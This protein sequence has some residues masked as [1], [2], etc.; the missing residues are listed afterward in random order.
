M[1]MP[2]VGIKNAATILLTIG[3]FT[4]SSHLG[5]VGPFNSVGAVAACGE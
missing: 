5:M 1:S 3:A 4:G 2:G